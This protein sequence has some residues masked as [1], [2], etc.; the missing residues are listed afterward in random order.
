MT[1]PDFTPAELVIVHRFGFGPL[2]DGPITAQDDYDRNPYNMA[3]V[4]W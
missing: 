3:E 2:R 1:A 4:T